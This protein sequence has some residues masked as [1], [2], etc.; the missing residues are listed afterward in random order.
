MANIMQHFQKF[1]LILS[2]E[3]RILT[4]N[5]LLIYTVTSANISSL[6]SFPAIGQN[7]IQKTLFL[8]I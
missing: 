5:H 2:G 4:L 7:V 1:L 6:N 8:N 3:S